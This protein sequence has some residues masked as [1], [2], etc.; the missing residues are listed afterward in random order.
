MRGMDRMLRPLIIGLMV[1][2]APALAQS[3]GGADPVAAA[4]ETPIIVTSD[5]DGP[6]GQTAV[7]TGSRIARTAPAPGGIVSNTASGALSATSGVDP[8]H[9]ENRVIKR[10]TRG[11]VSD[12]PA[13]GKAAACLL[14]DAH[15][16]AAGDDLA[17]AGAI[18]RY[19]SAAPAFSAAERL[20]GAEALFALGREASDPAMREEA[21]LRMLASGA[22]SP[23]EAHG[24]RRSL[25]TYALDR[26]DS[27]L[28]ITRLREVVSGDA[29][30]AQSHA[31]LAILLRQEG[32]EGAAYAMRRAIAIRQARGEPVPPGWDEFAAN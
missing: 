14:F 8:L 27:R 19:L 21:L 29:E 11:C 23:R 2:N 10:R 9:A 7:I 25:V 22:M 26:G 32:L 4:Q 15:S 17:G 30:D 18:Y 12:N 24:A 16:A 20:A 28:A 6:E 13:I 3:G 31:N 1:A 5:R